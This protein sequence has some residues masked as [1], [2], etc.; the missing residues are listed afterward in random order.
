[1]ALKRNLSVLVAVFLFVGFL[2]VA[3][4]EKGNA[5]LILNSCC[6]NQTGCVVVGQEPVLCFGDT[7]VVGGMCTV[8]GEGGECR[9]APADV[10][11]LSEW[12]LISMAAVLGIVGFMVIR[13]KRATA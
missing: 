11:T 7:F 2:F 4:P 9:A 8:V 5:G 13:R 3:L 10:P 12:G 6:I 1:M